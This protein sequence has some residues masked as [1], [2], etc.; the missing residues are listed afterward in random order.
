MTDLDLYGLGS[1]TPVSL[2]GDA[3][4]ELVDAV[5]AAWSR[6]LDAPAGDPL[7][8]EPVRAAL[9]HE[10]SADPGAQGERTASAPDLPGLL[11]ALT[12]QVTY[13]KIQ[14]QAGRLLL[15]HAGAVAHPQ[16]GAAVAFV[17][18]GGTGK[19]TLTRRLGERFGYL[20]DET[21][22]VD[23][24]GA[25]L[26]YPK[27][28][29]IRRTPTDLRKGET[30]P[31]A[32]GLRRAPE[33]PRLVRLVLLDRSDAHAAPHLEELG[34]ADAITA[35]A[36]ETSSLSALPRPLHWLAGLLDTLPAVTRLRYGEVDDVLD[37]AAGW[38]EEGRCG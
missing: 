17:A 6:C 35:L 15:L 23:A 29:S 13:A 37:L 9:G 11:Q 3:A 26:P 28:L 25:V 14:A 31:D 8:T 36:P 18:P 27:P 22:A 5:R 34:L 24:A 32:L 7:R 2:G 1:R 16:T 4:S 38:L 10:A 19:T 20:T 33:A 12:Q 21:V 30:S